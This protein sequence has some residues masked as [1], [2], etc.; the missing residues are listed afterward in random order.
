[1]RIATRVVAGANPGEVVIIGAGD[2]TLSVAADGYYPGAARLDQLGKQVK[3]A[4]GATKP[5]K[6][7]VDGSLFPGPTLHPDWDSDVTSAGY[8]APINAIRVDGQ[9]VNPKDTSKYPKRSRNPDIAAAWAF[10]KFLGLSPS[11]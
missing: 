7:I 11:A 5:T 2:P 3:Q 1:Y 8:G 6:V 4:L 9:R 10:A